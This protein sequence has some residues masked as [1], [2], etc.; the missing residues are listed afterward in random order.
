M[1][2]K[3]LVKL[4]VAALM[5]AVAAAGSQYVASDHVNV[6]AVIAAVLTAVFAYAKQSPLGS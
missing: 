6:S 4:G 5:A 3:V 1:D 2:T